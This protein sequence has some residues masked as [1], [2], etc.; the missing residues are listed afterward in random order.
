M[1]WREYLQQAWYRQPAGLFWLA[2]LEWLY[3]QQ[4]QSRRR[5][6]LAMPNRSFRAPLPVLVIGNITLGGTGK[7]P[8][9]LWLVAHCRQRGLRVGVVSRGYGARPPQYP[10]RVQPGQAAAC[11]GDEP[12]LIAERTGVP[13]VIDPNRPRAVQALL[14]DATVDLIISDDGLQHYPLARDLELVMLDGERGL[15]NGHCLP[16]GPLREPSERLNTVDAVI[17][18]GAEVDTEAAYAFQLQ[19][20]DLV[21]VQDGQVLPLAHLPSGEALHGVAGI[22]NPQRFFTTLEKLHWHPIAHAFADHAS[23]T[24]EMLHFEPSLPVVMTEKDAVKC[25]HFAQRDWYFLRVEAR[26]STAFVQWL[27]L[28][29]DEL[30]ARSY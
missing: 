14:A 19:P 29:L 16:R 22:G 4:V 13:V 7:T 3:K 25:R 11:S 18:N 1:S 26:L 23:Y 5:R 10:W 27:D 21:R 8:M 24:R 2:P 6:F 15:G 30:L 20:R 9:V 12:L 17:C 28:R